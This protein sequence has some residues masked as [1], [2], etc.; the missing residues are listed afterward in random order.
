MNRN[1]AILF[2]LLAVVPL[3]AADPPRLSLRQIVDTHELIKPQAGEWKWAEI[4]WIVSMKE[5]RLKAVKE[6]KP[7]LVATCAQGSIA[8]CL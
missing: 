2:A 4:P 7:L 3:Q 1:L 8:G 6:G 5:A